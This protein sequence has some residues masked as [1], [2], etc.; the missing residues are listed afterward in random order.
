MAIELG[1]RRLGAGLRAVDRRTLLG[2]ALAALA[3]TLVLVLTR[4]TA[5]V[6]VL[7]AGSDLPAGTPLGELDVTVRRVADPTGLVEGTGI[8]EL[9]QWQLRTPL[10]AGE[11]LLSSLLEPPA[12]AAASSTMALSL[13][14]THAVLGRISPGDRIDLYLT[15][16]EPGATPTS[17]LLAQ[18]VFVIDVQH[19]STP[20]GGERV[21]LLLAVDDELAGVVSAAAH[22]DSLDVVRTAP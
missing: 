6:P 10:Q 9:S 5:T 18:D 20:G 7:V 1:A 21:D 12:M 11:P 14:A 17:T 19:R 15:N 8:G 22:S 13:D 3:A 16:A 2:V 4:P